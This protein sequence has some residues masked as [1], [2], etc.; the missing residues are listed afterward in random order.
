MLPTRV[1]G[2]K[3]SA[4]ASDGVLRITIPKAPEAKPK[5]IKIQLEKK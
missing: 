3:A 4:S 5:T 2:D 1:E